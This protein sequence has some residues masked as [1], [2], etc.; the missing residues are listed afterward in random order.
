M[1]NECGDS[2]W[3]LW[4]CRAA[5]AGDPARGCTL[6]GV[7]LRGGE[8]QSPSPGSL[9]A[10]Q[11]AASGCNRRRGEDCAPSTAPLTYPGLPSRASHLPRCKAAAPGPHHHRRTPALWGRGSGS[12]EAGKRTQGDLPN[13]IR[14]GESSLTLILGE[15]TFTVPSLGLIMHGD[16]F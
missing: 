15:S 13:I 12:C 7:P 5:A 2:A 10:K 6:A 14:A 4:A 16:L 1:L 9:T 3:A 11:R 8:G